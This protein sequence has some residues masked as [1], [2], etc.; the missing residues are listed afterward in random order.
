ME[1]TVIGC[2]GPYPGANGACSGYLVSHGGKTWLADCGA[3][4]LGK[5]MAI[6]DPAELAGVL[7]S[8][9]HS[10]HCA[11]MLTLR[12]YL[13]RVGASLPVYL[14]E[15]A[16]SPIL[17]L[18]FG[19]S[20]REFTRCALEDGCLPGLSIQ[21]IPTRHPVPCRGMRFCA[22]G[23]T[24]V[25]TG[26]TNEFPGLAGFCENADVLF[27]DV[28]A[29]D[30]WTEKSGHMNAQRAA[31]LAERA[32]VKTLYL[33]HVS[34]CDSTKEQLAKARAVFKESYLAA[35]GLRVTV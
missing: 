9:L 20:T 10:D 34:P 27:C 31:A 35:P 2:Q 12:Y 15:D 7:L 29:G 25:Y 14:P 17:Q 5:L 33:T 22:D 16:D 4:V 19:G 30:E 21:T 23:K 28:S 26:D 24:L 11:D 32:G 8:H 13:G 6:C 3:G 18:L 1:W